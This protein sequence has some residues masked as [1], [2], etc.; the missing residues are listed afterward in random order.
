MHLKSENFYNSNKTIGRTKLITHKKWNA[1]FAF[2][3]TN[4]T[5]EIKLLNEGIIL[6]MGLM[7]NQR[8]SVKLVLG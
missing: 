2:G 7:G 3:S 5:K 6:Y 8:V 4:F 1:F